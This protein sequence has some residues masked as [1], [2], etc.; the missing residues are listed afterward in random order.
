M[1]FL[2]ILTICTRTILKKRNLHFH[3]KNLRFLRKCR[4]CLSPDIIVEFRKSPTCFFTFSFFVS[5]VN[6]L[7]AFFVY[8]AS[9][10]TS[11]NSIYIVT[12]NY[13]FYLHFD[14]CKCGVMC[15]I[16]QNFSSSF[17]HCGNLGRYLIS[18]W[19]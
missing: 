15:I 14:L 10:W 18:Y 13:V 4:S 3:L 17:L 8:S 7:R 5:I 6:G 1:Q 19:S 16:D 12:A 2:K 11:C 9:I